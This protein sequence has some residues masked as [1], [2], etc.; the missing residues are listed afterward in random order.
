M[1]FRYLVFLTYFLVA[2]CSSNH[3][4]KSVFANTPNLVAAENIVNAVNNKDASQYAKDLHADVIVKMYGGDIRLSGRE[5]VIENR[6]SHFESN[7]NAK[8]LLI[9][10][11]EIDDRVIMHDQVWLNGNTEK[12]PAEIVEIFTF[13]DNKIIQIDVIQPVNLFANTSSD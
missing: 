12:E 11:V 5:A 4:T 2:A 13:K 6:K 7:S 3:E 8:N 10:L 1:I 9:H